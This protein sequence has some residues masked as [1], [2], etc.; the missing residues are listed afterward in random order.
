MT[1]KDSYPSFPTLPGEWLVEP[2]DQ[3]SY[4]PLP[5]VVLDEGLNL[6]AAL[7]DAQVERG[8]GQVPAFIA[9]GGRT[10]TY[11]ELAAESTDLADRL[12]AAGVRPGHRIAVRSPNAP[13]GIIAALATWK[14]GAVFVPVPYLARPAELDIY[15]DDTE[16]F[17]VVL[18]AEDVD[19]DVVVERAR[20]AGV[21]LV[22]EFSRDAA[23]RTS[24]SLPA[25]PSPV[26]PRDR[27][28]L[29]AVA[30]VWHTGGTTGRPKGC[31]HTQRRYLLAGHS[32]GAA[33]EVQPAQRYAAAAPIG[34]AFGMIYHTIFTLLHGATV[35]MVEQFARPEVL[36]EALSEHEVHTF[37]AITASWAAMLPVLEA[38]AEQPAALRRGFA[39][40]Q[41]SSAG[42]VT[43]RWRDRGIELLNNFGSTAFATWILVARPTAPHG[44]LGTPAPGYEVRVIDPD[45]GS[46]VEPGQVGRL[47]IRGPS[48]LTYWRL[49]ERQREDVRDGWILVDD[50]VREVDGG[51]LEYLG[52]SDFMIS[53]SGN[54]VAPAEVESVIARHPAVREVVVVGLPD[55]IRQE[56]VAAFVV[57]ERP[58]QATD[59]LRKE[60]QEL[61]KRELSPYKYPRI[62]E[63][64]D[65]LPRDHVGKV[66]PK[67]VRQRALEARDR[68]G[69]RDHSEHDKQTPRHSHRTEGTR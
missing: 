11:A 45:T 20:R 61:V 39:M 21:G 10:I 32:I 44:A 12:A 27:I 29:D 40:W 54:K 15:Y 37:A 68:L 47:A 58:E 31:Y 55:P 19:H 7:S 62:L 36:I 46:D 69:E 66:Q 51:N 63:Y 8:H 4:Q 48:G 57:T 24:W 1:T 34:H 14:L 52:R 50:L 23:G 28:P 3:P 17:A 22:V 6:G 2:D 5:G 30:I 25:A 67:L 56:A 38:G 65:G 41:S 33:L 13:E 49:P 16:P 42:E 60:L 35:V 64:L 59:A 53:T 43:G 9:H 18:W 26:S